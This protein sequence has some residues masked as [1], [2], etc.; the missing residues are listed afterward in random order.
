MTSQMRP[1]TALYPNGLDREPVVPFVSLVDAWRARVDA[2]PDGKAIA[3]FDGVLTARET[4]ELSDALAV[5]F[6]ARGV[7]IGR[8]HV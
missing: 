6:A 8:A 4:D 3:Y 2:D 1:W 7:Q 5:A